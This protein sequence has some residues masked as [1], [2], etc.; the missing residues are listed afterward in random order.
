VFDAGRSEEVAWH[1]EEAT[2][3]RLT[4]AVEVV[5]DLLCERGKLVAAGVAVEGGGVGEDGTGVADVIKG[6]E[7]GRGE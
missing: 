1:V 6:G 5:T 3:Q 2:S 7:G 4:D